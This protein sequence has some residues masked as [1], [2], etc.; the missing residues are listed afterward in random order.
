LIVDRQLGVGPGLPDPFGHLDGGV[1]RGIGQDGD[2][3][4]AAVAGDEIGGAK[5]VAQHAGEGLQ[6]A[7]AHGVPVGVVDLLEVV[8]VEHEERRRPLVALRRRLGFL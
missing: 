2:E 3:L 4:F 1:E 7:V 6:H 5:V 8:Q